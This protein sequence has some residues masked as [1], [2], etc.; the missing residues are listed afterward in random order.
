M[1]DTNMTIITF[2]IN[3]VFNRINCILNMVCNRNMTIIIF[4]RNIIFNRNKC[5]N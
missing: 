5:L 1:Y 2:I 3:I 4:I